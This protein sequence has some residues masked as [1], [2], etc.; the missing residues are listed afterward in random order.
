MAI[1]ES[2]IAIDIRNTVCRPDRFIFS[3]PGILILFSDRM[4]MQ[5]DHDSNS[6]NRATQKTFF[7]LFP[8]T[9]VLQQNIKQIP[10]Y[11]SG[12]EYDKHNHR[13]KLFFEYTCQ[14]G[15]C[16]YSHTGSANNER[17]HGSYAH[18]LTH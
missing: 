10:G 15:H 13:D 18:A 8:I 16:R 4:M 9:I 2:M 5:N 7:S 17:Y 12:Q 1:I 11:D 3:M 6:K 14:H